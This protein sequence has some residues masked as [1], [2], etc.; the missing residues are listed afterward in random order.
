MSNSIAPNLAVPAADGEARLDLPK[1]DEDVDFY[2]NQASASSTRHSYASALARYL[3]FCSQFNI[4]PLPVQKSDFCR[5]ASFLANVKCVSLDN[6]M[7][8]V[9]SET[10]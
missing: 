8:P 4:P 6:K 10:E 2:F 7:L 5:F 9:S 3:S 1:L